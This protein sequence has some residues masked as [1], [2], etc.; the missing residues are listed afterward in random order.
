MNSDEISDFKIQIWLTKYGER[1]VDLMQALGLN[2]ITF[3]G[4]DLW[5]H[6]SDTQ[7]RCNLFGEKRDCVVGVVM[8]EQ[9]M[10]IKVLDTLD[11]HSNKTWEV[12]SITIPPTLNYPDG[13][14]SKIPESMFKKRSSIW[15]AKFLRNLKSSSSTNSVLD[16]IKGEELRGDTAYITLKNTSDDQVKLFSVTCNMSSARV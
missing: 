4:G 12:T 3:M 7:D 6:N 13:M 5:I 11:V 14:E 8:N 15:R 2:F 1:M 10:T 9:P 16:A